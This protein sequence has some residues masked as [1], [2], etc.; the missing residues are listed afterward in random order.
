MKE[1]IHRIVIKLSGEALSEGALK[2]SGKVLEMIATQI[3]ELQKQK[4]QIALVVGGGNL[5]RGRELVESE[6]LAIERSTADYVGM[7]ATMQ[8]ALVLR[9]YF[10]DKGISA[11]VLSAITVSQ[12]CEPYIPKRGVRHMEKGRVVIFAAGLGVPFF[13]T[14]TTSVQRALELDADLLVLAKHGVDGLYNADPRK[15]KNAEKY[16]STTCTEILEKGL[17]IADGAAIALAKDHELPMKVVSLED[18]RSIL[19][20][21]IGTTVLPK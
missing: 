16:V 10:K 11:R 8:N 14:D 9:D 1:S 18:I 19:D 13:T 5:F 17:K 2:Y 3:L 20:D 15:E 6:H 7:L 12:L 4:V 21:N